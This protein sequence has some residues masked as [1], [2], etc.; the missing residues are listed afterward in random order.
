MGDADPIRDAAWSQQ[1]VAVLTS[2][3]LD[4][5]IL[6]GELAAHSPSVWPIYVR[7]GLVWEDAEEK[8][9]RRYLS[10]IAEPSLAALT[11]FEM[12]IGPVYGPHWS[13]TG[14]HVPAA[15]SPDEAVY[16]PGRNLLLCAQ[17][18][19]WCHQQGIDSLALAPLS[20]NPFSDSSPSFFANLE[21]LMAQALGGRLVIRLPYAKLDKITV[22]RRGA[23]LPLEATFSCI[24]PVGDR[25]C[26]RC[27][28]CAERRQG[29]AQA[30]I[31]DRTPY[32]N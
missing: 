6:V 4:S 18:A 25:H 5:A 3:G 21:R 23:A 14:K 19:V 16:L 32:A 9:L 28:K 26:G 10:Q 20:S 30:G 24:H 8:A 15:D 29:F 31:T 2:G 13:T 11:V 7:F 22:M 12:P 17:P 27:N 1:P